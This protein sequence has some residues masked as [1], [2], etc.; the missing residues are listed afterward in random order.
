[1][2]MTFFERNA[3]DALEHRYKVQLFNSIVGF[4]NV[5]LIA[6]ENHQKQT[7]VAIF[8]SLVHI[9]SNPPLLGVVFRPDSVARHTYENILETTYYTIN[10]I[11]E[12]D[13]AA[14]HQTSARYERTDSEFS[15][16]GLTSAYKEGFHA[17]YVASSPI[18]F[19]LVFRE[20]IPLKINGTNLIIGEVQWLKFPSAIVGPDGFAD[21]TEAK[22]LGCIGLD[23]YTSGNIIHRFEYA[24]T[25]KIPTIK[26]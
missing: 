3:F 8:N 22:I 18:A 19:G 4:K 7:N 16:T 26:S 6:T 24:K 17:P 23:A 10:L 13:V 20:N 11:A 12:T 9:G 25:D 14:A 5:C 2:S 21:L 1:M 15:A